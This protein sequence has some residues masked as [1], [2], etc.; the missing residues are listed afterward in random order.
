MKGMRNR[1]THGYFDIDLGIIWE[2]VQTALPQLRKEL[3]GICV[4]MAKGGETRL[5]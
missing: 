5:G 3:E 2:T 4:V 1:M